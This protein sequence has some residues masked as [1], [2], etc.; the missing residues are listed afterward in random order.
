MITKTHMRNEFSTITIKESLQR[1]FLFQSCIIRDLLETLHEI[2][3]KHIWDVKY[4]LVDRKYRSNHRK[5]QL[6]SEYP[7]QLIEHSDRGVGVLNAIHRYHFEEVH[8]QVRQ[9]VFPFEHE[10]Y[11]HHFKN[12]SK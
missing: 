2:D 6:L 7:T 10:H 1:Y 4:Q 8:L 5:H 3:D 12:A 11:S 9:R